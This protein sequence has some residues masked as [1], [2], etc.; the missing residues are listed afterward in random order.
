M[1]QTASELPMGAGIDHGSTN[2]CQ[3]CGGQLTVQEGTDPQDAQK[4]GGFRESYEC[5]KCGQTGTY[6]F[7]YADGR[8]SF[9]GACADYDY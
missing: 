1:A 5:I 3:R 7:R 6:R 2:T 8:E 4:Q 9:Q